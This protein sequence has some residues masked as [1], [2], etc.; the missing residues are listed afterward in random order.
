MEIKSNIEIEDINRMMKI[1]EVY[2]ITNQK[3]KSERYLTHIIQICDKTPKDEEILQFKI[4]AL[5]LLDKPYKSLE[6]TSELLNL[7]PYNLHALFNIAAHM[8]SG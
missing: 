6:T 5:N 7:N 2:G 4:R 1:A 3:E 8:R